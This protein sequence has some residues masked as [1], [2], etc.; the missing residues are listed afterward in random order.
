MP[1]QYPPAISSSCSILASSSSG[2]SFFEKKSLSAVATAFTGISSES[3]STLGS[4]NC[5]GAWCALCRRRAC[6]RAAPPDASL[7]P[8]LS[9]SE[10]AAEKTVLLKTDSLLWGFVVWRRRQRSRPPRLTC[11]GAWCALCR[12]RACRRAAPPDA[13]LDP[14][15]S[16]SEKAAEKTV[17]LKTDSLLWG[18]FRTV[19]SN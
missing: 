4:G 7:D 11:L 13:S 18:S 15:L 6:R 14:E 9:V 12:R 19:Q 10:K 2:G 16:V 8:E 17:L 5:L 1:K 3:M